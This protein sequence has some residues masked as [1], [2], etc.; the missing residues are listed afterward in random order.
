MK[1]NNLHSYLKITSKKVDNDIK[2]LSTF[3]DEKVLNK[4]IED[5]LSVNIDTSKAQ[6]NN[7][8]EAIGFIQLADGALNSVRDN[9]SNIKTL[10]VAK[11][12]ATLDSGN[13][14]A[15]DAEIEKYSKNI[16]DILD[17]TT[18]NQKNVFNEFDFNGVDVNISMPHFS[19]DKIDEFEKSLNS[20]ISNISA[21][22]KEAISKINNLSSYI[23]N[24][25]NSKSQ[26]GVD[27]LQVASDLNRDNLKLKAN[28]L[29]KA[30][31]LNIQNIFGLVNY[32]D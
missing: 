20:A 24:L 13:V 17:N 11:N 25:D 28:S 16:N 19:I 18:F 3:K 22:N 8:N 14:A 7:F 21:F 1:V 29:L 26:N 31:N 30:H 15:I 5:I 9:L 10:Q 27:F 12:N 23:T 4:F 2:K 6:I 32:P